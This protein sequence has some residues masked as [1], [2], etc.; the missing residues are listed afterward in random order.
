MSKEI[1]NPAS[2][3]K[4]TGYSYGVKASGTTVYIAGQVAQDAS[5]N[6]VGAGDAGAQA[7][8]VMQNLKAVVEAAG[9]TLANVVKINVYVTDLAYRPAVGAVRAKYFNEADGFPASTFCVVPSLAV[10]DYLV[11]IEAIAV[12]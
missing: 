8:Q 10:P 3:A 12:L 5:G 11:E 9:G 1:I 7:E 4:P 6:V 2:M